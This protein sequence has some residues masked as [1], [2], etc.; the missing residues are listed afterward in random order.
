ML[1]SWHM[2][3]MHLALFLKAGCDIAWQRNIVRDLLT[4]DGTVSL[5]GLR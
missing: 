4:D 3:E 2:Y 5:R 1:S